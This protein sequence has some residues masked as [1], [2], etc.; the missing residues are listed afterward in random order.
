MRKLLTIITLLMTIQSYA[1]NSNE[2]RVY[3]GISQSKLHIHE[4]LTGAGG[5][6]LKDF[7]EY[8]F[9]YLRRISG[10]LYLETGINYL[11]AD[12]K[13]GYITAD[14]LPGESEYEKLEIISIP[15]YANYTFLKYLF[16]NGGPILDFQTSDNIS[17]S[18]SGIGYSL[19]IGGKYYFNNLLIFVNP[20]YKRHSLIPFEGKNIVNKM[21]EFGVQFGVGYKF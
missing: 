21:T 10:K 4:G 19:G 15:I 6:E 18:Q 17:D 8:G 13:H 11:K 3:Y 12:V 20:N 9:K 2:L 5:F 14:G 1:Q 16:I 7:N